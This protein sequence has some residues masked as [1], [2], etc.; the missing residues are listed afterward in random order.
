MTDT[1]VKQAA[2]KA[3][4]WLKEQLVEDVPDTLGVVRVWLSQT[5]VLHGRVGTLRETAERRAGYSQVESQQFIN[6]R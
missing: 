5:T 1:H 6:C 4:R 2:R 3:K